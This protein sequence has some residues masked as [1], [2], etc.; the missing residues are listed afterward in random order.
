MKPLP[1][2]PVCEV[3]IAS[4]AAALAALCG[5][6]AVAVPALA[7]QGKLGH[8]SLLRHPGL[9]QAFEHVLVVFF[10]PPRRAVPNVHV[11]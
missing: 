11:E 4:V 3:P 8:L 5:G 1:A 10:V 7:R 6:L 2:K 9:A